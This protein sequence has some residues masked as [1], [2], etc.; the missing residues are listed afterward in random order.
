MG[1]TAVVRNYG[2]PVTI[3]GSQQGFEVEINGQ[4]YRWEH[5]SDG[6]VPDDVRYTELGNG[7]QQKVPIWL[8]GTG[9]P[10]AGRWAENAERHGAGLE[11]SPG[12]ECSVRVRFQLQSAS[13]NG[14]S[15]NCASA[16]VTVEIYAGADY[17]KEFTAAVEGGN[18]HVVSELL[19]KYPQFANSR[20]I[21]RVPLRIAV[22]KDNL[23]IVKILLAGGTNPNMQV[24]LSGWTPLHAAARNNRSEIAD[25]LLAYGA[26]KDIAGFMHERPFSNAI[27]KDHYELARRLAPE[28]SEAQFLLNVAMGKLSQA[29]EALSK[30]PELARSYIDGATALHMAAKKGHKDIAKVLLANRADVN[31]KGIWDWT[32][33]IMA[34]YYGHFDCVKLLLENGARTDCRVSNGNRTALDYARRNDDQRIIDILAEYKSR[35]DTDVEAGG[36]GEGPGTRLHGAAREGK[37]AEVK[38]LIEAGADVNAGDQSWETPLHK[39]AQRVTSLG[40]KKR[41]QDY[42]ETARLLIRAGADVDAKLEEMIE[43]AVRQATSEVTDPEVKKSKESYQRRWYRETYLVTRERLR[44]TRKPRTVHGRIGFQE[45]YES[46]NEATVVVAT[47][48]DETVSCSMIVEGAY[49]LG[50]LEPGT[51]KIYLNETSKTPGIMLHG[52]EVAEDQNSLPID[53]QLGRASVSVRAFD[54]LGNPVESDDVELLIGGTGEDTHTWKKAKGIERGLW[55][56]DHLYEGQ[57][58]VSARWAGETKGHLCELFN[59]RNEVGLSFKKS[60]PKMPLSSRKAKEGLYP[61]PSALMDGFLELAR[62]G[63]P[64]AGKLFTEQMT[65]E[66]V[67]LL[68]WWGGGETAAQISAEFQRM[69]SELLSGLTDEQ[70]QFYQKVR[71]WPDRGLEATQLGE[72]AYCRLLKSNKQGKNWIRTFLLARAEDGR[73]RIAGL[74]YGLNGYGGVHDFLS[75]SPATHPAWGNTLEYRISEQRLAKGCYIDFNNQRLY[76]VPQGGASKQW[77]VQ[78]G[79]DGKC[80]SKAVGGGGGLK[81]IDLFGQGAVFIRSLLTPL[82]VQLMSKQWSRFGTGG[83]GWI[84][85]RTREGNIGAMCVSGD[86]KDYFIRF[87]MLDPSYLES[88]AAV[89]QAVQA[90]P[91]ETAAYVLAC[92]LDRHLKLNPSGFVQSADVIAKIKGNEGSNPGRLDYV[93]VSGTAALAVT[94]KSYQ[95]DYRRLMLSLTK[96]NGRWVVEDV[97][98]ETREKQGT[99]LK[100]FLKRYPD[101]KLVPQVVPIGQ[102]TNPALDSDVA[103]R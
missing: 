57:Y 64:A 42:A 66:C 23:E 63:D 82:N 33:L 51:Y 34:A 5:H 50:Q 3:A 13:D 18:A 25:V 36:V 52:V 16:P 14:K 11:L 47:R 94:S 30:N 21:W 37:A 9:Y 67:R 69:R 76:D 102:K 2:K 60:A 35:R 12:K 45:L 73:W 99:T 80:G 86:A 1:L 29:R 44:R 24:V 95:D 88:E 78:N 8:T 39:A 62:E 19:D 28:T 98:V 27:V 103:P 71:F 101:A 43:N 7:Q 72:R 87:K 84:L 79:V 90:D 41:G 56:V 17:F 32:P 31:A 59:G 92:G 77:L 97:Q 74:Y 58:I 48:N 54:G 49:S 65:P 15:A 40:G 100:N 6:V 20:G 85:F 81:G 96:E 70:K 22:D 61:T 26:R 93:Y 91:K 46:A 38:A 83:G 55:E 68:E 75:N 53:F 4:W 89:L 10:N